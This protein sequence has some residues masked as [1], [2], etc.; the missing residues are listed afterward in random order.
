MK[1]QN[2]KPDI[3]GIIAIIHLI[4]TACIWIMADSWEFWQYGPEL[5]IP[6]LMLGFPIFDTI[7]Y[8][9]LFRQG[10]HAEPTN[11][12]R[13]IAILICPINSYLVVYAVAKFA[14]W[15]PKG[16]RVTARTTVQNVE[17]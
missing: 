7:I 4:L 14:R 17:Q 2:K 12:G 5:G 16:S 13:T 9:D 6:L 1:I 11:I 8:I 10:L 15:K 3:V